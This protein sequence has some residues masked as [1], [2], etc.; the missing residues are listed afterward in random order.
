MAIDPMQKWLT[1]FIFKLALLTSFLSSGYF[2]LNEANLNADIRSMFLT[3]LLVR[4]I[5]AVEVGIFWKAVAVKI[6]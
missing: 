5:I 3:F 6:A 2:T 1:L 4:N